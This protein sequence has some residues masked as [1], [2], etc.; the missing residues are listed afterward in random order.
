MYCEE[1]YCVNI[2]CLRFDFFQLLISPVADNDVLKLITNLKS[3]LFNHHSSRLCTTAREKYSPITNYSW[4][5]VRIMTVS[6]ITW[7]VVL[8]YYNSESPFNDFNRACFFFFF[9]KRSSTVCISPAEG[10]NSQYLTQQCVTCQPAAR[11]TV[12]LQRGGEFGCF[13]RAGETL[14]PRTQQNFPS[15]K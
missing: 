6:T 4:C 10:T 2:S 13:G 8:F 12:H 9:F 5:E 14:V 15:F 3:S 11:S 1:L 7:S